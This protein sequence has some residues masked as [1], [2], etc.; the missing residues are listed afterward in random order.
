MA[1]HK[2]NRR[3]VYERLRFIGRV[4]AEIIS[5]GE[6]SSMEQCLSAFAAAAG[7][8]ITGCLCAAGQ[9]MLTLN[10]SNSI[11][12]VP[13]KCKHDGQYASVYMCV[14]IIM[15]FPALKT[16]CESQT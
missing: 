15:S 8:L 13:T 9:M 3:G 7:P 14:K 4:C 10:E 12:T 1:L 11:L 2:V 5:A 6:V 16:H